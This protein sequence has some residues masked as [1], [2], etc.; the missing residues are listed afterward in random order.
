MSE[1]RFVSNSE[2]DTVKA[3]STVAG[4]LKEGNVVA[5]VGEMGA[6]KTVFVRGLVKALRGDED[7]VASPTFSLVI[8][9]QCKDFTLYHFD[10]YRL[11]SVDEIKA[12]F[13]SEFDPDGGVAVIEWFDR[14]GGMLS[15]DIRVNFK[16]YKDKPSVREIT[17][18]TPS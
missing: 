16:Y 7:V 13:Y 11:D 9:I 8:P 12:L 15:A 6:G 10:F 2:A 5:L 1:F 18:I 14:A 3:A 17:V 4:F